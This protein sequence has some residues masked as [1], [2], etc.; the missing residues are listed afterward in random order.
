MLTYDVNEAWKE[1]A[2]FD[3]NGNEM[4]R[5]TL[6]FD[7]CDSNGYHTQAERVATVYVDGSNLETEVQKCVIRYADFRNL[8]ANYIGMLPK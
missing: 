8:I 5:V 1:H 7:C 4:V 6:V 2:C 3:V